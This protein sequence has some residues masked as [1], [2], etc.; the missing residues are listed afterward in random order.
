MLSKGSAD[1]RP[2]RDV[3]CGWGTKGKVLGVGDQGCEAPTVQG[4]SPVLFVLRGK[5][6]QEAPMSLE[7]FQVG[8][9]F[10]C[11]VCRRE[12]S[13]SHW[14]GATHPIAEVRE[15]RVRGKGPGLLRAALCS[16]SAVCQPSAECFTDEGWR[17]PWKD[18]GYLSPCH[19]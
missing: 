19:G 18:G 2:G 16:A 4:Q 8:Q 6:K 5:G 15:R 17:G 3:G 10:Y 7:H 9:E 11:S 13:V 1:G 12:G 14:N